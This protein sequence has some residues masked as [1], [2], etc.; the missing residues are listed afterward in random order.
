MNIVDTLIKILIVVL[1]S[2]PAVILIIF[3]LILF[4]H[5]KAVDN[6]IRNILSVD[7]HGIKFGPDRS[8]RVEIPTD[9]LPRKKEEDKPESSRIKGDTTGGD[10]ALVE[11]KIASSLSGT[12]AF[13]FLRDWKVWFWIGNREPKKYK[14]YVKIKFMADG[15]EEEVKGGYYG[16][17]TAWNLNAFSGIQ[18]PGLG[19][20]YKIKEAANQKKKIKIEINCTVKDE[21]DELVEKKLPNTYAYEYERK[22]WYL[23]P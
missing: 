18:A 11:C 6:R 16:G 3:I 17:I 13:D 9:K 1:T 2:W 10:I 23:E 20:P 19:I 14:A 15:Y 12:V 22:Y 21:N 8:E 5:R 7:K 4:R